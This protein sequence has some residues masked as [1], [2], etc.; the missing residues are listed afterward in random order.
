MDKLLQILMAAIG[1]LGFGLLFNIRGGKLVLAVLGATLSWSL[2][3]ALEAVLPGEPGRYFLS[4]IFVAVWAELLARALKTPA[5]TFLIPGILPHI[6]GGA[7]YH[8]MRFA[9]ERQWAPCLSR[10]FYTFRLALSL[11]LGI[12]VVLSLW[13][14]VQKIVSRLLLRKN[15]IKEFVQ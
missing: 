1:T 3:V 6:P 12:I 4:A 5:T 10:A 2:C 11:A 14:L 8:T 15:H 7:L 9:L 13:T